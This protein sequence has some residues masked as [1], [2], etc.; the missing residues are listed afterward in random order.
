MTGT[1]L[2]HRYTFLSISRA[3]RL[4]MGNFADKSCRENQNTN[5]IFSNFFP[6]IPPFMRK[7]IVERGRPQMSIWRVR[8][9][10]WVPKG[11]YKHSRICNTNCLS[12]ITLAARTHLSVTIYVQCSTLAVTC[13]VATI[14]LTL[15]HVASCQQCLYRCSTQYLFRSWFRNVAVYWNTLVDFKQWILLAGSELMFVRI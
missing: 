11:T 12:T 5:F 15:R 8:I 14:H 13:S 2:E 10:C 9:A 6:K 1:L 7:N 3:V 4:R